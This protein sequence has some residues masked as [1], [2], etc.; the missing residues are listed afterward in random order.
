VD[1]TLTK[2]ST[3]LGKKKNTEKKTTEGKGTELVNY[4]KQRN[5]HGPPLD[6][7]KLFVITD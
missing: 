3:L 1:L 2:C 5:S 6:I 7:N 4:G